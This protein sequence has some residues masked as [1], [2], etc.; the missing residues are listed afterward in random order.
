VNSAVYAQS[1]DQVNQENV[2]LK[3]DSLVNIN[4]LRAEND[5]S[6]FFDQQNNQGTE[7][8]TSEKLPLIESITIPDDPI[9]SATSKSK[10]E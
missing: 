3:G 7:N 4:D 2:T 6:R 9:F 1:T 10:P 8:T 5:F